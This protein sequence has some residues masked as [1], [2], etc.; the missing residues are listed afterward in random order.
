MMTEYEATQ[1]QRYIERQIRRYK[2]EKAGMQAAELPTEESQAK[3]KKW[4]EIQADFLSQTGLKRQVA[5]ENVPKTVAKSDGNDTIKSLD[6]DDYKNV[7]HGKGISEEVQDVIF[8]TIKAAE[9][10]GEIFIS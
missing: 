5:R 2:R 3:I 6:I 1:R 9:K 8:N 10:R 7:L 4:E